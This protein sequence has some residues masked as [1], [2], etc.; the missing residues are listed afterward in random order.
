[1]LENETLR[2]TKLLGERVG[3]AREDGGIHSHCGERRAELD[4]SL[5][6]CGIAREY[7]SGLVA[8]ANPPNRVLDRA[9]HVWMG[10]LAD[11]A[12]TRG[13]IAWTDEDTIHAVHRCNR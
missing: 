4:A 12:Q 3:R 8:R 9:L 10:Q 2:N 6:K 7:P 1:M 11:M 13:K 5:R